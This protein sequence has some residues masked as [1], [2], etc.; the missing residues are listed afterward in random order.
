MPTTRRS[1][2]EY[3]MVAVVGQPREQV[4][5]MSADAVLVLRWS[6]SGRTVLYDGLC[7]GSSLVPLPT[8]LLG[9]IDR[10]A[11]VRSAARGSP[12]WLRAGSEA[13][14]RR[15]LAHGR[16][17]VI[18][19]DF[20]TAPTHAV[21]RRSWPTTTVDERAHYAGAVSVPNVL[22][23]R[24]A[25]A[26]PGRDL[27]ARAQD[28]PRAAALDR[29]ARAPSATSASTCPTAW[30]RPTRTVVD[31][32]R[33]RLHRRP[34]AG[35][36]ARREGAHRGVRGAR[37]PRAHPQGHDLARPDRE[38]RAAAGPPVARAGARPRSWPRWR[39]S[40]RLAAEHE[41][42]VMAGPLAQRRGPGHHARQAVRHG[43]RRAAGGA[44]SG[45]RSCSPA[46]R[47]AASRARWA[48]RRTCS[49]CSTATT[50]AG[51]PRAARSPRH[52][53]FGRVLD[54]VGQ[55]YPRSLDFD[56]VSA[57]VQLVAGAVEP[58]HHDPADGRATSW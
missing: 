51:R 8:D 33:P 55:V 40:A 1:M 31:E 4:E 37:R 35:H 24:Y 57:L 20:H 47:C 56:V 58:G 48:P 41:A 28:R 27:V 11:A 49:T 14:A 22:A 54:S 17:V 9:S 13:V 3:F 44:S 23:T 30:S 16:Y 50:E 34:R 38:R 53:G 43:R 19:G 15:P 25:G 26:R 29:R 2:L 6:R 42:T 39:G 7:L 12:D 5:Q 32:R 36:P 45:S 18:E 21:W 46:T 10:A 52:L